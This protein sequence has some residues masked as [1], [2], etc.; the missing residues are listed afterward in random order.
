MGAAG[1]V[2][3]VARLLA[4]NVSAGFGLRDFTWYQY[5]FTECRAFFVYLRLLVLPVG[6]S[7]DWDYPVSL[8]IL[9]RGAIVALAA[10]LALASAIKRTRTGAN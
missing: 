4:H 6:Q 1:G 9:D 8:N 10:I 7:L 5:F 3:F 2:A